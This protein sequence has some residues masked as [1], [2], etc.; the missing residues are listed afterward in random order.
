MKSVNLKNMYLDLCSYQCGQANLRS[1][2]V[3][4]HLAPREITMIPCCIPAK[5]ERFMDLKPNHMQ[6][7]YICHMIPICASVQCSLYRGK[8]FVAA[9]CFIKHQQRYRIEARTKGKDEVISAKV[10]HTG[11]SNK[12]L[13]LTVTHSAHYFG[14]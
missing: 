3:H 1:S 5:F 11:M 8:I 12:T 6:N 10:A 2:R 13:L 4:Y 7:V 14:Y 9:V